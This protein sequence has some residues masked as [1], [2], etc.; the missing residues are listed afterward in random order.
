LSG[1]ETGFPAPTITQKA[2][3]VVA[4]AGGAY[5]PPP[6]LLVAMDGLLSHC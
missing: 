3:K 4:G 6:N 1:I 2:S 5:S